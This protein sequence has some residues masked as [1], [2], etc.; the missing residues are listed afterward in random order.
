MANIT[1]INLTENLL[2]DELKLLDRAKCQIMD[3]IKTNPD[4][5][6]VGNQLAEAQTQLKKIDALE[7]RAKKN[8]QEIGDVGKIHAMLD[9]IEPLDVKTMLELIEK[10]DH[11]DE[12]RWEALIDKSLAKKKKMKKLEA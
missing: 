6:I 10:R 1:L 5:L 2:N 4:I 11:L 8:L 12:V 3:E 7:H 9:I